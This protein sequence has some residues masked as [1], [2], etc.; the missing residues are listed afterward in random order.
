MSYLTPGINR[1]AAF[2]TLSECFGPWAAFS[3]FST[4]AL[5]FLG[6]HLSLYLTSITEQLRLK[7]TPGNHMVQDMESRQGEILNISKDRNPM[8]SVGN[9]FIWWKILSSP[10][11]LQVECLHYCRTSR[12]LLC[13]RVPNSWG[14]YGVFLLCILSGARCLMRQTGKQQYYFFSLPQCGVL[15]K[16]IKFSSSLFPCKE[17]KKNECCSSCV[18]DL[19]K[20]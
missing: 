7:G 1:K 8:T 2:H 16:G 15:V 5:K 14:L 9:L 6:L 13:A 4:H 20:L 19:A 18:G 17:W 10:I 12:I 3:S 11:Y